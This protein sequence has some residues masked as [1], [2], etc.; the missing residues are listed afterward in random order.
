[1]ATLHVEA[2]IL[3]ACEFWLTPD[4]QG[5]HMSHLSRREF[6][7]LAAAAAAAPFAARRTSAAAAPLSAQDVIDRIKKNI[8]VQWKPE[9][10][11]GTKAGDP[12]TIV[13]G[14]VT[15]SMAT[16]AVLQQA[17][18]VGANFIITGHPTFYSRS[19]STTPPAG[20]GGAATPASPDPVFA[21]KHE[22]IAKHNLVVFRLSDHWRL[23][24]P[25]PAAAGI[26]AAMGWTKHQ[27][28]SDPARFGI[29]AVTVDA[30][31]G[32]IK[33]RLNVRGGLRVVGDPQMRVQRVGLLPGSTPIQAALTL[34]PD[35]DAI[36]A[37]EVREWE[38][39]EYA[40]DKV[41]AGERKALILVGRVVS[42]EAGMAV[43]ATWL[44]PFLPGVPI[45]HV[46]AGDP[47]WRPA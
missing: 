44:K 12:S 5:E 13:K 41:S 39:V 38:S 28:A 31:A 25:N 30:L 1:V 40:R 43:C 16:L 32:S 21:A 7:A 3:S 37:G 10:V 42:E 35:V 15:T 45:R 26:A 14:I 2:T 18:K 17:A 4:V 33:K 29:P 27:A 34:L 9:S 36:L 8:G 22:F 20:R 46:A 11:D 6:A 47:Y 24:Q 23:R 19:D